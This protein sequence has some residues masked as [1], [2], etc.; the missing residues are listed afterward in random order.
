MS[1]LV[2]EDVAKS[3]GGVHAISKI[4]LAVPP[5]RVTGLI[6]PNGAGKTTVVN[7]ITGLLK[8]TRGRIRLDDQDLT[9]APPHRVA[10]AG[11][12]RTFQNIRLLPKASVVDNIVVGFHQHEKATLIESLLGL[13]RPRREEAMFVE[14]A[15][16]LV[17]RFN[18]ARYADR[19]AGELAYGDQRRVEI[20][21]ALVSE[22]RVLLL[23]EPVAGMNDVE[24]DRIGEIIAG[25][26]A[27]NIG[28]LLIE[29]NIRFVSKLCAEIVVLA[30]GHVIA[31][32]PPQT[33]MRDPSVM[34][35]YLGA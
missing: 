8:L 19:P 6:G 33:V 5:G 34:S 22:P 11:V 26:T 15:R 12:A 9:V 2:L 14:R 32:G 17:G 27:Q 35:A 10:R 20:M 7:M 30:E 4:D 1:T 16:A 13:P 21:R 18:M 29:H 25:L 28:I 24:A 3:F 23:D 31:S